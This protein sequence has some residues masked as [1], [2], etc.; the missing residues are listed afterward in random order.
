ML[1][2]RPSVFEELKK[3]DALVDARS[4]PGRVIERLPFTVRVVR[5]EEDLLKAVAGRQSAYARHMP[6]VA[7]TLRMPESIDTDEGVAVLLAESK[8][9]GSPLGTV[10]IQGNLARPLG[11]ESSV[12]LPP[13][14]TN[15]SLAQVS[16]LGIVQGHV[17]RL[18]KMVLFKGLFQYWEKNGID[19]AVVAARSPLDRTYQQ[20]LFKDVFP[21]EGFTPLAH[22]NNVPHRVMAFEV[23]T[24][25]ERW[26]FA[27]HPLT[28]FIFYT[29][30]PDLDIRDMRHQYRPYGP[31]QSAN[32]AV[33]NAARSVN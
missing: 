24:A 10:R 2:Q 14:L 13:W 4:E 26:T 20:L 18:V 12:N 3:V 7:E 21:N 28:K 29:E 15:E 16:R 25:L 32:K 33:P 1:N 27:Q 9:D 31:S 23:G 17:G 22:M 30:H 8:L 11:L 6:S 19:W 5:S